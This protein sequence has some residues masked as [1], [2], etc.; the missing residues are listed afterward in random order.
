MQLKL[1]VR[2]RCRIAHA[3]ASAGSPPYAVPPPGCLAISALTSSDS[4]ESAAGALTTRRAKAG[5]TA[6]ERAEQYL[7]IARSSNKL[8]EAFEKQI[9]DLTDR[10]KDMRA[11]ERK[12][13]NKAIQAVRREACKAGCEKQGRVNEHSQCSSDA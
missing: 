4:Q 13:I 10:I 2:A 6:I 3:V 8:S 1:Q 5:L 7:S 11:I 12:M 9:R